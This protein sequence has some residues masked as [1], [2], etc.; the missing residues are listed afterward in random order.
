MSKKSGAKA[1]LANNANVITVDFVT[2]KRGPAPF[3]PAIHFWPFVPKHADPDA[4]QIWQGR[5]DEGSGYGRCQFT[6]P[7]AH[8]ASWALAHG[9]QP[10]KGWHVTHSCNNKLCVNPRHLKCRRPAANSADAKRDGLLRG[11]MKPSQVLEIVEM[12]FKSLLSYT[13]IVKRMGFSHRAIVD[14][15]KGR[16]WGNVTGI[17]CSGTPRSKKA[18][19][20]PAHQTRHQSELHMGAAG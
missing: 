8:R 14:I 16:T 10:S 13:Q 5:V 11:R 4:C 19:K 20:A 6:G 15:C 9:R 7:Y 18:R 12:R 2:K 3:D 1:L 17:E